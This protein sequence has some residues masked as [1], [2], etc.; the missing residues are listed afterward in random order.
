MKT[1]K[2]YC[3]KYLPYMKYV[4][5]AWIAING[6]P[7]IYIEQLGIYLSTYMILV[8][9]LMFCMVSTIYYDR[10]PIAVRYKWT[11]VIVCL[12]DIEVFF[13]ILFVQYYFVVSLLIVAAG[14][15]SVVYC[16][17]CMIKYKPLKAQ[18]RKFKKYCQ[19]KTA[20]T[21]AYLFALLLLIPA[22]VGVYK[23]YI[24]VLTMD[25]WMAF[26]EALDLD[27]AETVAVDKE[28]QTL[29]SSRLEK[30]D[31]LKPDERAS[32]LYE[33]GIREEQYLGIDNFASITMSTEKMYAYTLAY[34]SNENRIIR[35]NVDLIH[36]YGVQE[37]VETI[38][39]E[40]YHA[41]QHYV[42]S[43]L[44][45]SS[46]LVLNSYYYADAREWKRN[47]DNYVSGTTDFDAYEAQKLESDARD[48]ATKRI[49]VYLSHLD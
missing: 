38:L 1:A 32:L 21:L 35:I 13:F 3:Q 14:I 48:Y 20:V 9:Y 7:R 25:E 44:D 18:T 31:D 6:M 23:E 42:V 8:P 10:N 40:V 37:N 47:M 30:W 49:G 34:Y 2:E 15:A 27:D 33:I 5:F 17:N 39:H 4:L 28:N 24:D 45:F 29:L 11:P 16:Y 41:Y 22:G 43:T 12:L 36:N 46:D 19:Q 26:L